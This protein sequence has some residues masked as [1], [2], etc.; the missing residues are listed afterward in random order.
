MTAT[1]D[2]LHVIS[3]RVFIL[4]GAM[5][6]SIQ[7]LDEHTLEDAGGCLERINLER[8]DIIHRIHAGFLDAGSMAI[9]TNSF[10]ASRMKLA[11][12]GLASRA[13]EINRRAAA[14]ARETADARTD[15]VYVIGS[16]GPTG[17]LPS[18]T[19]PDKGSVSFEELVSVF[20]EQA[21]ALIQGGV[22]ALS[23][24][25]F[26]DILEAK[27]AV[28]GCREASGS[29]ETHIPLIAHVTLDRNGRMLMGTDIGSAFVTLSGLDIDVIGINCS[30]GPEEMRDAVRF[31]GTYSPM[32]V[33][34]MP[35][36][37]IPENIAG[38]P[39]F[40]L[41]PVEFAAAM[42]EFVR[43]FG[44]RLA[45]GCCGST[46][47]HIRALAQRLDGI[48]LTSRP[49]E[50]LRAISSAMN[51]VRL[52][53]S[54][55]PLIV[56]ERLNTQGSKKM[57]RYLLDGNLD[58][59][60][61]MARE[62]IAAGAHA[63]DLC[64]ALNEMD[65][66][67]ERF[68]RTAHV[69]ALQVNAPIL[70]D[71]TD[72][73]TIIRA[74]ERYPGRI[75]VNSVNL[76]E[77]TERIE[78]LGDTIRRYGSYVIALTI[79]EQGMAATCNRKVAIARRIARTLGESFGIEPERIIFDPLTFSLATGEPAYR[80]SAIETL[81]A[82]EAIKRALPGCLTI[83]G[84]SNV[85]FGL[86]KPARPVLNSVLL[87]HA[88]Q[89]GL[90]LAI[91]NPAE[92]TPYPAI[93]AGERACAEAL[94]FNRNDRALQDLIVR[95][96][97]A[98][99][100]APDKPESPAQSPEEAIHD[101]ILNRRP[102]GIENLIDELL[103]REDAVTILNRV[104][105]P[106]MK[107]VGDKFGSGELIL[108]FVLQSAEVMKRAVTHLE[109]HIDSRG[110]YAKGTIVLA[111]VHGDVHDIGKNLV[112]T[113][114]S[115]N[116]YRVIDLGKQ[117]PAQRIVDEARRSGADAVGLSALLVS[118]SRQMPIVVQE[119]HRSGLQV[120]VIIGGAAVTPRFARSSA[121][122]EE[123]TPYPG[124]VF[125]A[126]DAFEALGLL[127]SLLSPASRDKLMD[128][129]R[130]SMRE[131][132]GAKRDNAP[133]ET[134]TIAERSPHVGQALPPNPPF[135]GVR[136]VTEFDLDR[137]FERIDE[138]SLYRLSWGLRR[139]NRRQFE[140]SI[141]ERFG[142]LR[143]ELQAEAKE[144]GYLLPAAA[145]GYF[146]CRARG[147]DLIILDPAN[148][149]T[150]IATMRFP[151]QRGKKLL[152][153]PDYFR[154]D[155]VDIVPLQLVTIGHRAG[156]VCEELNRTGEYTK[157]YFLHGLSV[158]TAEALARYLHEHIREELGLDPDQGKRYSHG[159][160]PCPDLSYNRIYLDLLDG[161]KHLDV[162]L[163]EAFQFVPEQT[164][165]A[166]IVHHPQ[167]EYFTI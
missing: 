55:P 80:A 127:D 152:S 123:H 83:L 90:D 105:L 49:I 67:S 147:N 17:R 130:S 163:T 142:P 53:Q 128:S 150:A 50:P 151:R 16:I 91:V 132:L 48:A 51:F 161:R 37:G 107:E 36:M 57:K 15:P 10:G 32:P 166:L 146:P 140:R 137:I 96:E 149:E 95:F 5:G 159:Y 157:S 21:G 24:E 119:L 60:V 69:L 154:D 89:R 124:G 1:S 135:Q 30:T 136:H 45:G 109:G 99:A 114:L 64:V 93:G 121:V 7:D 72:T 22:D 108:P 20:A 165:A 52:E 40:P 102:Q 143:E 131:H 85:S 76:E 103:E 86:P 59:V 106:A 19:D 97:T 66:E 88:L 111:T 126:N 47:R 43:Q 28:I 41:E 9:E 39:V 101:R 73:D 134:G 56:G 62:Q 74:I 27:A 6:T 35:N 14:I 77:G 87:F 100:P 63:L 125:Y 120:P 42:E 167:A 33:S 82:L 117:V 26:Q 29:A 160:P 13:V 118:T 12:Y 138:H 144:Q 110:G 98:S 164:T 46:P 155:T 122:M 31:L 116:G 65:G 133:A 79:D 162:A 54:P 61:E 70:I 75:I 18:T 23:I 145:Y 153:L 2:L 115:N 104:L 92:I 68:A 3:Q 139:M 58:A 94:L 34:C 141:K 38:R 8:P 78:A 148:R 112:R 4:D 156:R 44:V 71:S 158:E 113:I 129:Y 11:E 81:D 25:T 84:I